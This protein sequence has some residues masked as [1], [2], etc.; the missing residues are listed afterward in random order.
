MQ[1]HPSC[2][3]IIRQNRVLIVWRFI[4]L[5]L[6]LASLTK[7]QASCRAATPIFLLKWHWRKY[8]ESTYHEGSGDYDS[9]RSRQAATIN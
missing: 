2:L 5:E 8:L 9:T 3:P 1:D 4:L 7:S 6:R